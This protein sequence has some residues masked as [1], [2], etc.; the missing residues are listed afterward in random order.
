MIFSKF[1]YNLFIRTYKVGA[2]ITALWSEKAR[3]WLQG[4]KNW[5]KKLQHFSLDNK[6]TI[7]IHCSSLGEFEQAIPV[8][9]SIK[10]EFP[11]YKI[12]VSFFS[13]SGFEVHKKNTMLDLVCYLPLDSKKN[14]STF[15]DKINP[16]LILFIKYEFWFYYLTEANKRKIPILL[17]SG[18]FRNNQPFFKWYGNLHKEMLKCF[19]HFFLQDENSSKLLKSI[20]YNNQEIIG[21]TRFERVLEIANAGNEIKG[22]KDFIGINPCI[23]A[24]STWNSDD[25]ILSS[26]LH[27]NPT[28]K[29]IVAPHNVD[30]KNIATC[31]RTYNNAILFSEI[32][33]QD[34]SKYQILII[35]KMGLL[36]TLYKYADVCFVGGGFDK[37]NGV[38]NTIEAA[39][40]YKPIIFGPYYA[41]YK[42]AVDLINIKGAFSVKTN[43]E[44]EKKVNELFQ[45]K[46]LST[47]IGNSAGNYVNENNG[48]I[49][50]IITYIQ[51]NRLL[52][53]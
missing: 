49:Q 21:D 28:I 23:V 2:I 9:Q 6:D 26:F 11:F 30:E 47:Q 42:E 3:L 8:I 37:S 52:T 32:N 33:I 12:V 24:G 45:N 53:K 7:W 43:I 44:F 22:I 29:C 4:R 50:K 25:K 36:S 16:K 38:H 39:V 41:K 13:P 20:S 51:A 31:L 14:V 10:K 19:T 40:Y 27:K 1:F 15:L 5:E 17:V 35:N 46:I 48:S 18:I 34:V